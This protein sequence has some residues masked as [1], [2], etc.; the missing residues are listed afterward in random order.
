MNGPYGAM[1]PSYAQLMNYW[2]LGHSQ[3]T[4]QNAPVTPTD[5]PQAAPMSLP[6]ISAQI[7][8]VPSLSA[9]EGF[10]VAP[11]CRQMMQL[12]DDSAIVIK[13]AHAG[14]PPEIDVYKKLPPAPPKPAVDL[15]G[16]ATLEQVNAGF[17]RL[18][19]R[20]N[21]LLGGAENGK[22]I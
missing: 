13:T 10:P 6:T 11:E 7:V 12:E 5:A 4:A 19:D 22:P 17:Q 8:R 15:S 9:A 20:I 14:G 18:E 2:W 16:Y 1:P 3:Q 21:E